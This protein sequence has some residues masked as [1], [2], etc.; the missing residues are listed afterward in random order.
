MSDTATDTAADATPQLVP[1]NAIFADDFVEVLAP[2]LSTDT[3]AEVAEK[4]AHHSEGKR[5]RKQDKPK[6]VYHDDRILPMEITVVEAGI[7]PLDHVRVDY[8]D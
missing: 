8:Q 3:I 1:I 7:G 5:V 2:V 6:V 4:V